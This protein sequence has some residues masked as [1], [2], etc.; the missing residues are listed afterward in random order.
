MLKARRS[1]ANVHFSVCDV[2]I[3]TLY[4]YK[5]VYNIKC[6]INYRIKAVLSSLV[7]F[8]HLVAFVKSNVDIA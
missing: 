6:V 2:S 7:I 4:V 8:G 5:I 3:N 1:R